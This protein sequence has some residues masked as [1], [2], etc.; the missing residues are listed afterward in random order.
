MKSLELGGDLEV[1]EHFPFDQFEALLHPLAAVGGAEH[2]VV[3]LYVVPELLV[4]LFLTVGAGDGG[5]PVYH[6]AD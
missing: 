5:V 2:L 4:G 6:P 1:V 3:S